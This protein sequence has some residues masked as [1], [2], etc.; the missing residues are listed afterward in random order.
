[1]EKIKKYQIILEK[2]L[3]KHAKVKADNMPLVKSRVIIDQAKRHFILMD[4]GWSH[5]GFIHNWVFH[6]ELI[7]D[8]V[9][10]HDNSTDFDI[11]EELVEYGI[12]KTDMVISV[13]EEPDFDEN[14]KL[15]EAA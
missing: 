3:N 5:I 4:M 9:H 10:L 1:M 12:A 15:K 7:G 11:I 2:I 13:L 14:G 8:K 6:F